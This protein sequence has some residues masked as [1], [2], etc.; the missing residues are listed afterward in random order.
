M[1][2]AINP[3]CPKCNIT[4]G[5]SG[6]SWSGKIKKQRYKCSKCGGTTVTKQIVDTNGHRHYKLMLLLDEKQNAQ[7]RLRALNNE[8]TPEELAL[9]RIFDKH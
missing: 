4:M 5:K 2:T 7:L 9:K 3:I 8:I 6:S 1:E